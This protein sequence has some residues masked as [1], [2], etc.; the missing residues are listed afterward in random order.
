MTEPTDSDTPLAAHLLSLAAHFTRQ[1]DALSQ[2][3]LYSTLFA[4]L[5][6]HLHRHL[7]GTT[8]LAE[9]AHHVRTVVDTHRKA[10][11]AH[12]VYAASR[13]TQ[14]AFLAS[15]ADSLL[16]T[17]IGRYESAGPG[18]RDEE[19]ELL[20]QVAEPVRQAREL[21][22]HAA[23][24]AVDAAADF[25]RSASRRRRSA[26][27][28]PHGPPVR[29]A[30]LSNAQHT[31]LRA[32]ARGLVT[33]REDVAVVFSGTHGLSVTTLRSLRTRD[34]TEHHPFAP[35][36]AAHRVALSPRGRLV[37]AATLASPSGTALD[38]RPA[39]ASPKAVAHAR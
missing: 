31:A 25:A 28:S 21:I 34:L 5:G 23:G 19:E 3:P 14:L 29:G 38:P 9:H 33:V 22:R 27:A 13:V 15:N 11:L 24:D 32:V 18:S 8:E 30:R 35:A 4:N 1:Q 20:R 12:D 6:P 37:L 36:T 16:T 17:A 7:A 26:T 10:D 2:A 39:T